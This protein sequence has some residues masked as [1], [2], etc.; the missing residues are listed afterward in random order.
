MEN[1]LI[2]GSVVDSDLFFELPVQ[3]VET[4]M[5]GSS[6]DNLKVVLADIKFAVENGS[7][8][9]LMIHRVAKEETGDPDNDMI[10]TEESLKAIVKCA[11][12][13]SDAGQLDVMTISQWYNTMKP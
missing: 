11:K 2:E 8:I 10:E 13:Y 1:N 12:D 7:T 6:D 3:Y 9:I 5:T 4:E